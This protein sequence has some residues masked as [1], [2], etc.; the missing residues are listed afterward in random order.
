MCL[1]F[2]CMHKAAVAT[3]IL[4]DIGQFTALRKRPLYC[5]TIDQS[6]TSKRCKYI[7][8]QSQRI[9]CEQHLLCEILSLFRKG[10]E[11]LHAVHRLGSESTRRQRNLN[12]G[13]Q[14]YDHVGE[15]EKARSSIYS[16]ECL[17]HQHT[18]CLVGAMSP[19]H[20]AAACIDAGLSR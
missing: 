9:E 1:I 7:L 13:D 12:C 17:R 20:V 19:S 5:M 18:L 10:G 6:R 8:Q 4:S 11:F 2:V 3:A 15:I 16:E 14:P